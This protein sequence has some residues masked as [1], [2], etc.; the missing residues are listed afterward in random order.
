MLPANRILIVA[1]AF[2][3]A[4]ACM[5]LAFQSA[6]LA[7][8]F[9]MRMSAGPHSWIFPVTIFLIIVAAASQRRRKSSRKVHR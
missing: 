5:Y 8:P 7:L 6:S 4:S 9:L 2:V 3:A 1:L